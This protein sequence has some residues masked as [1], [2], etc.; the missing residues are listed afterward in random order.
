MHVG[1]TDAGLITGGQD[2]NA[3]R[4]KMALINL[5]DVSKNPM[6]TS[7]ACSTLQK[8]RMNPR[9]KETENSEMLIFT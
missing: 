8:I 2:I 9:K 3:P 6:A 4:R 7:K 5:V 1:K